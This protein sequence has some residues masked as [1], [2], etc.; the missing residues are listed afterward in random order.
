MRSPALSTAVVQRTGVRE[1]PVQPF[2][3]LLGFD[4]SRV[5]HQQSRGRQ[6]VQERAKTLH[7]PLQAHSLRGDK[8]RKSTSVRNGEPAHWPT[9]TTSTTSTTSNRNRSQRNNYA[10]KSQNTEQ[11]THLPRLRHPY[12]GPES[13]RN[14]HPRCLPQAPR[15]SPQERRH[16]P[17]PGGPRSH[18]RPL[19]LD[20][21]AFGPPPSPPRAEPG[22]APALSGGDK[23]ALL[24]SILDLGTALW[25][26]E[27]ARGARPTAAGAREKGALTAPTAMAQAM[28]EK[29]R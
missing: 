19:R 28:R 9:S 7:K 2:G 22:G 6:L 24:E 18:Q 5:I 3:E 13:P 4:S 1:G 23:D 21:L 17:Q 14:V 16:R 20:S 26:R 8:T 11:G 15:T 27:R 29:G 25:T 12:P 10:H